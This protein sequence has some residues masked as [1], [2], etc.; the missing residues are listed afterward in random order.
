MTLTAF[1]PLF[2]NNSAQNPTARAASLAPASAC[3]GI[4]Y[5]NS[6]ILKAIAGC[7]RIFRKL[8]NPDKT[9]ISPVHYC[10]KVQKVHVYIKV[11][12]PIFRQNFFQAIITGKDE[13][14]NGIPAKKISNGKVF[15]N[16]W[17][18][19][20]EFQAPFYFWKKIRQLSCGTGSGISSGHIKSQGWDHAAGRK[21]LHFKNAAI[22][23]SQRCTVYT[24]PTTPIKHF[25][26]G[27]RQY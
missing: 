21:K 26:T 10:K 18:P 16:F 4:L 15:R 25:S 8:E 12:C 6:F 19:E 13:P 17:L 27:Y 5:S 7:Q 2:G 20:M 1:P 22:P 24:T 23:D 3:P 11:M 9:F 14:D